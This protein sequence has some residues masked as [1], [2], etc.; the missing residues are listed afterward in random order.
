MVLKDKVSRR[1]GCGRHDGPRRAKFLLEDG[2][3]VALVDVDMLRL[4]NVGR[5]LRGTTLAVSCDMSDSVAVRQAHQKVAAELGPV[6]ILVNNA[7]HP[8]EQQ[9]RRRRSTTS[10]SA[11]WGSTSTAR[12]IGRARCCRA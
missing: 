9:S 12:S 11:S 6:D 3:K 4:D 5:F 7:G 2:A 1:H 10:G 8:L